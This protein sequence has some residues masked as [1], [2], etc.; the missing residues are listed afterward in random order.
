MELNL[1]EFAV[2]NGLPAPVGLVRLDGPCSPAKSCTRPAPPPPST[3]APNW[4]AHPPEIETPRLRLRVPG[5]SDLAAVAAIM[6]RP[7]TFRYS[8]RGPMRAEE[9][10]ARL[11]R[12]HGHWMLFGYG[13]FVVEE[14]RTGTLVG[15]VGLADFH[16][17]FGRDFDSFPEASW[18]LAPSVWGRGYALEAAQAAHDWLFAARSDRA[19]VCLIHRDN[20]RSIHLAHK[21]GYRAYAARE[22]RGYDALLFRRQERPEALGNGDCRR[23]RARKDSNL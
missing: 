8:E 22:Y 14:K 4:V 5:P 10:W 6:S 18:T 17:G 11:L 12:H 16:R 23:W 21:L 9:T 15:E 20:A 3:N 7:E 2:T 19:T 13:L 1:L